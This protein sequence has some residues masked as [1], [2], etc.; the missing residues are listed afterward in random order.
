VRR[1]LGEAGFAD[2]AVTD[3]HKPIFFGTDVADAEDWVRG[4]TCTSEALDRLEPAAAARALDR[5]RTA[6]SEHL[7]DG[8]VRFESRAWLVTA[9]RL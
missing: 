2:L 8:G 4:F 1:V 7:T 6:L 9:R 5:L 3:V